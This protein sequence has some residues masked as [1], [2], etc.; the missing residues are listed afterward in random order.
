MALKVNHRQCSPAFGHALGIPS[1][2]L[3]E[4]DCFGL[5]LDCAD[6]RHGPTH[7]VPRPVRA[8]SIGWLWCSKASD[9]EGQTAPKTASNKGY[10]HH[11]LQHNPAD[12]WFEALRDC[13]AHRVWHLRFVGS[14]SQSRRQKSQEGQNAQVCANW[15]FLLILAQSP[16]FLPLG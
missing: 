10:A 12:S 11:H 2:P 5:S 1:L 15:P 16:K 4:I 6:R 3:A 9:P 13:V 7:P 8:R 14:G